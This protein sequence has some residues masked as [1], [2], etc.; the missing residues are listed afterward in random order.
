METKLIKALAPTPH[1]LCWRGEPVTNKRTGETKVT[2][3]PMY[4]VHDATG[5]WVLHYAKT[6]DPTTWGTYEQAAEWLKVLKAERKGL[7]FVLT[8]DGGNG[9]IDLDH[10]LDSSTRKFKDDEAGKTAA[11]VMEILTREGVEPCSE[12]S[13]SGEGL[14]IW[15][16]FDLPPEKVKGIRNKYIEMYR[17]GRFIA[18]TGDAYHD[19]GIHDIQPAVDEIIK[20]F[21]LMDE[22]KAPAPATMPG[23]AAGASPTMEDRAL[24]EVIKKSKQGEKFH[25]LY[26]LGEMGAYGNDHSS[27]DA[28]LISMLAYYTKDP[29]QLKRLFLSSALGQDVSRKKHH[30]GDYL[31]RTIKKALAKVT[32]GYNPKEY[33]A[34]KQAE[35]LNRD[36][37]DSLISGGEEEPE[38][39]EKLFLQMLRDFKKNDSENADT[40]AALCK[41]KFLYCTDLKTWLKYDGKKWRPVTTVELQE[42]ARK[43]VKCTFATLARG[44]AAF[45]EQGGKLDTDAQKKFGR[46]LDYLNGKAQDNISIQN[47]IRL[48]AGKPGTMCQAAD[49]DRDPYLLNCDNG[50]LNLKT[51]E[52]IPH[53]PKHRFMKCTR[54]AYDGKPHSTL[55][56]NTMRQIVPDADTRDYVQRLA[57]YC[58]SGDVGAEKIF[59]LHGPGGNGKG[60]F[61]ETLGHALGDY[62]AP[63][64]VEILLSS[65]YSRD[66]N[67]ATPEKAKL[68]G[69]RLAKSSESSIDSYFDDGA[70]KLLTGGDEITARPLHSNPITF[71]PSHKLVVSTNHMPAIK[72][73]SDE[74]IKRRLVII[75][76]HTN[77]AEPDRHLKSKLMEPDNMADCLL[78][79]YEG[80]KRYQELG[81]DDN[82]YSQKIAAANKTYYTENDFIGEFLE[83]SC[84]IG[85][86]YREDT[87]KLY[88]A[89]KKFAADTGVDAMQRRKFTGVIKRR[90]NSTIVKSNGHR[91]MTG[92]RIKAISEYG[93]KL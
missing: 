62:A 61:I 13:Q 46:I 30:E 1:W 53:N 87:G 7:G 10:C 19:A 73:V 77:F 34:Q 25:K 70:L 92:I 59:F 69:V 33:A 37:D 11:R 4:G 35:E 78:W 28:A 86:E 90:I 6:N 15:G 22:V 9:C 2:K 44:Y 52:L 83:G 91:Y 18:M 81:L 29:E 84:D 3:K 36:F 24:I 38:R 31:K 41:G 39:G 80:F 8:L 57:G 89:Y 17:A 55:W 27:A 63:I 32:E 43:A 64:P 74:G 88:T 47:S 26:D 23:T 66:G 65:K 76:F 71:S 72:D 51:G 16:K 82:T 93:G 12:V 85:P 79:A 45:I 50:V 20:E 5:R 14:H 68:R 58:M 54:A 21:H 40:L 48:A 75:P 49:F 60:V 42:P 56:S 67:N